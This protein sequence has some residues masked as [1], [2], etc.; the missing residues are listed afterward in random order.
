MGNDAT[1]R[2]S[3]A[4][5]HEKPSSAASDAVQH[6]GDATAHDRNPYAPFEKNLG[7][8]PD[9]KTFTTEFDEIVDAGSLCKRKELIRLRTQ[10]DEH[11]GK[12]SGSVGRLANR[13]QRR[14]RAKQNRDWEF[15]LEEGILDTARLSRVVVNPLSSLSF[16]HEKEIELHDTVAT[17]LIDNSGSMRGRPIRLAAIAADMMAR[18]L[19]RCGVKVEILGFTTCAWKGGRARE[20]W[21][22]AGRPSQPGRLNDLR[23]IIY[24][25]ADTPWSRARLGFGLMLREPILKENIDGE[26]LAWAY[27]RL[28]SRFERRKI[29][30]VIS[31]GAPVDDATLSANSGSFLE[32]HL[33]RVI[34]DIEGSGQVELTAIGIGHDVTRY[35]R[36]AVTLVD[37]DQLGGAI[38]DELA[39]LLD[40]SPNSRRRRH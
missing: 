24:K 21:L 13:L 26:A 29:L 40:P 3:L 38:T 10:L 2:I 11:I 39:E 31:D 7:R 1:T 35:Y 4:A 20:R 5:L 22:A 14:L 8:R 16:K 23:H 36:R 6:M 37:A 19:E 27:A 34:A 12:L 18:T 32:Q 28:M 30:I 25:P 9:Y 17:C 33:R 15:D